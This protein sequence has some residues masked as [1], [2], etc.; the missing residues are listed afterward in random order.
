[1]SEQGP[2]VPR[3]RE[4]DY[5]PEII[6]DRQAF[7]EA[8]TG[9][10]LH[11]S[12]QFSYDPHVMEGNIEN[13]W[14]VAQV[15]IGVAGPL[16]VDGEHAQGE[17]YVP[18][19]TVEGTM[20]A[21][22]NRGMKV[23]RES[24]G[25]KTT[26]SAESMQ[27]APLFIFNDA[28]EARDFQLWLRANF[29]EIKEKAESTTSVGKL[30]EIENYHVH[31]FV[32]CRFDYSTGDA[33]GQNMTSRATFFACEWIQKNYPGP[34]KNYMLSGNFDTE[35]KTSSV[36]M[37]KGRGRRVTAE[38]TIPRKVLMDNLRIT[39][40]QMQYG[41]QITTLSGFLTNS[42]NNASHPANGL[43]ALYLATGQDLANIGESN[44]CTV[45]QRMTRDG[46][47]YFSITLPSII[48]A[49][50]GGG[51]NLPTQSECLK[52]MGCYGKDKA[53]KLCEIAAGLVVA[54]ELSLAAAT[55]V[56]KVTRTNEWVDAH[57]RLG[58]NR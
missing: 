2:K 7:I 4:D 20:L 13:I 34:L 50:Y 5:S 52:M 40:E 57:E 29:D 45:Y 17:F 16:L 1:M 21:S 48:M 22:Y 10:E 19:A 39:P 35:K 36:N 38:L 54:G 30:L 9:V 18:M 12:K 33:A 56:D 53:L 31:N 44:Q 26:V 58:R 49:S 11:H 41:Y 15:P 43:A 3:S 37:L 6:A 14:G 8:Q 55:R 25:V 32:A 23:I 24:G 46:D 27:R 47:H 28:R 51:T 42:S